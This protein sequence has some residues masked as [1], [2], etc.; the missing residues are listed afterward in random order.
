MN[1]GAMIANLSSDWA[2]SFGM[3][4]NLSQMSTIEMFIGRIGE[5][6][7]LEAYEIAMSRADIPGYRGTWS[8]FCGICWHKIRDREQSNAE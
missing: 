8:Y 4:F 6:K 7:V 5:Q 1:G 2:E 3:Y